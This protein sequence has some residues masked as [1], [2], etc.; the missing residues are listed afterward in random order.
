MKEVFAKFFNNLSFEKL[1]S[2][3]AAVT[4]RVQNINIG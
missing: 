1:R 4:G 3:L 2:S